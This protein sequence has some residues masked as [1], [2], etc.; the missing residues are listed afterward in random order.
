LN[1]LAE[2][3]AVRLVPT[4]RRNLE[5]LIRDFIEFLEREFVEQRLD[6]ALDNLG[7]EFAVTARGR[8]Q[9]RFLGAKIRFPPIGVL[10]ER[11]D[12]GFWWWGRWLWGLLSTTASPLLRRRGTG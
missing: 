3:P 4:L 10:R 11:V 8:T 1:D 7:S 9:C 6:F 5:D 2:C 12:G